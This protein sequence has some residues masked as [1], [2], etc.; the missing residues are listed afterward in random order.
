MWN[1][2]NLKHTFDKFNVKINDINDLN[3]IAIDL[4]D[5]EYCAREGYFDDYGKPASR[6]LH[7]TND[8]MQHRNMSLYFELKGN[9]TVGSMALRNSGDAD[10]GNLPL[11]ESFKKPPTSLQAAQNYGRRLDTLPHREVVKRFFQQIIRDIFKN[12]ADRLSSRKHTVVFV[13]RP[14]S[15][16]WDDSEREYAE[17]LSDGLKISGYSGKIDIVIYSEAE[18]ALASEIKRESKTRDG[19]VV[20]ID[21][22]SSTYDAVLLRGKKM[23]GRQVSWQIGASRIEHNLYDLFAAD[24]YGE[25][26][27]VKTDLALRSQLREKISKE[28]TGLTTEKGR[29]IINLRKGKE[30]YFGD[31]GNAESPQP[32]ILEVNKEMKPY[33]IDKDTINIAAREMEVEVHSN[34]ER[35]NQRFDSF[36]EAIGEFMRA[37][38]KYCDEFKF[39][40]EKVVLTGG[41]TVMPFVREITEEVFGREKVSRAERPNYSVVEGLAYMGCVEVATYNETKAVL[42]IISSKADSYAQKICE[43]ILEKYTDIIWRRNFDIKLKAWAEQPQDASIDE[44]WQ[45]CEFD[46]PFDDIA[47]SLEAP[48]RDLQS[49][50]QNTIWNSF[51]K[52]LGK[53]STPFVIGLDMERSVAEACEKMGDFKLE[54]P[55]LS[56]LIGGWRAFWHGIFSGDWNGDAALSKGKRNKV[57]NQI[58]S[59]KSDIVATALQYTVVGGIVAMAM[60]AA[61]ANTVKGDMAETLRHKVFFMCDE[62]SGKFVQLL[63]QSLNAQVPDYIERMKPYLIKND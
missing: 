32:F 24:I 31:E 52:L 1:K 14:A 50:I 47:E 2:M 45:T 40:P 7:I 15:K 17:L 19:G 11:Y 44:W 60:A 41:S 39:T 49:D 16:I 9:G 5:G 21:G 37:V 34:G 54:R 56:E 25:S 48:M 42:G 36:A 3:L 29:L 43:A 30:N 6:E 38:K 46:V 59:K 4:G 35:G 61:A 8:N 62:A 23:I 22:G 55:V 57:F 18:A 27:R 12:N 58:R 10:N 28:L 33:W 51:E 20:I 26:E 63:K 53:N 13:G